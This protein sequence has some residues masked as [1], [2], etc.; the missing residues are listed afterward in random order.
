[1]LTHLGNKKRRGPP[2]C[3]FVGHTGAVCGLKV[4]E[5]FEK[6]ACSCGSESKASLCFQTMSICL[7]VCLFVSDRQTD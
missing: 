5:M 6:H 2:A 7:F 4:S 3:K 1:M